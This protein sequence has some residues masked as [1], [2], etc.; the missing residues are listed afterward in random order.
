[1]VLT[2]QGKGNYKGELTQNYTRC[3]DMNGGEVIVV[4]GGPSGGTNGTGDTGYTYDGQPVEPS[5]VIQAGN[6][7]LEEGTDYTVTYGENTNAGGGTVT[8]VPGP[9]GILTGNVTINFTIDRASIENGTVEGVTAPTTKAAI[10]ADGF[11]V[12]VDGR[13][14]SEEDYDAVVTENGTQVILTIT[15]KGNYK[16]ELT[17]NYTRRFDLNGGEV[18]VVVGGPSGGTNGTGDTGY[19]YD[20]QPVEPSVVIQAGNQTLEEGTDYT[21]TYGENTNAGGGTV[22]IVPGPSGILTGNVTV[23][24][25]IDRASIEDGQISGITEPVYATELKESSF[26]LTVDNRTLEEGKD[27]DWT[28]T[29]NNGTVTL[30]IQ[31]KGNY[32]G[33]LII[34]YTAVQEVFDLNGTDVIVTIGDGGQSGTG[35]PSFIFNGT[36]IKPFV[37]VRIINQTFERGVDYR[38]NYIDNVN[39]GMGHVIL[40]P[41]TNSLFNNSRIVDFVINPL[42]IDRST[43]LNFGGINITEG[44][45]VELETLLNGSSTPTSMDD[46]MGLLNGTTVTVNGRTLELGKDF[47]LNVTKQ[48]DANVIRIDISGIGNYAGQLPFDLSMPTPQEPEAPNLLQ[49]TLERLSEIAMKI[50]ALLESKNGDTAVD[51][52]VMMYPNGVN[53]ENGTDE[54]YSADNPQGYV[55]INIL[56]PDTTAPGGAIFSNVTNTTAASGST[57]F[58]YQEVINLTDGRFKGSLNAN[59]TYGMTFTE[60]VVINSL[61]TNNTATRHGSA[62]YVRVPDMNEGSVTFTPNGEIKNGTSETNT[63]GEGVDLSEATVSGLDPDKA[64]TEAEIEMMGLDGLLEGVDYEKNVAVE[65]DKDGQEWWVITF[66][67]IDGKSFG[68]KVVRVKKAPADNGG[69]GWNGKGNANCALLGHERISSMSIKGRFAAEGKAVTC[70]EIA[71]DCSRCGEHLETQYFAVSTSASNGTYQIVPGEDA[72]VVASGRGVRLAESLGEG[73]VFLDGDV[74]KDLAEVVDLTAQAYDYRKLEDNGAEIEFT[75]SLMGRLTDGEHELTIINGDGFWPLVV[76]VQS[77]K[78]VSLRPA[79]LP[80]APDM[81]EQEYDAWRQQAGEGVKELTAGKAE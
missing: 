19:T 75:K 9:S 22:T 73:D 63:T 42:T 25:T 40:T 50:V 21:V 77:G 41:G 13:T 6:Q 58:R 80:E 29:Q 52:H 46:L 69:N 78:I 55:F 72:D 47:Q 12:E 70:Y 44:A 3:F 43:V 5:V 28:A 56:A 34:D 68:E 26:T 10:E 57:F 51:W 8:I 30:T 48:A 60:T 24:F 32:E 18:T 64:Y 20:G 36:A 54:P 62:I 35:S 81:T 67:A 76:T 61:F 65:T 39:V 37:N 66:T 16:G 4:V 74:L 31:G 49:V 2:I 53:A 79:D 38:V 11:T 71:F 7:T 27:F 14:L 33:E 45:S 17:Q 23:N 59:E 1:M 15:G